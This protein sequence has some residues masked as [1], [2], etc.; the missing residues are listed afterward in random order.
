MV[1]S[2]LSMETVKEIVQELWV[3]WRLA[4]AHCVGS[5]VQAGGLQGSVTTMGL[6]LPCRPPSDTGWAPCSGGGEELVWGLHCPGLWP[7]WGET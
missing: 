5:S 6:C 3:G 2:L 7:A 4:G 1:S